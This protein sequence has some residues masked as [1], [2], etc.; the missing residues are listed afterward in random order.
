[1][2]PR[3]LFAEIALVELEGSP[4]CPAVK[5]WHYQEVTPSRAAS[6]RSDGSALNSLVALNILHL[7][8][9]GIYEPPLEGPLLFSTHFKTIKHFLFSSPTVHFHS[10]S[11][12]HLLQDVSA[13]GTGNTNKA[14]LCRRH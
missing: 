7:I 8:F 13:A 1:M 9:L 6:L 2:I 14:I 5:T 4:V 11:C 12:C 10:L 3:E